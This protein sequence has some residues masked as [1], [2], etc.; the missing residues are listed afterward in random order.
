LLPAIFELHGNI[1]CNFVITWNA[2]VKKYRNFLARRAGRRAKGG[3][4]EE[5]EPES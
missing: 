3:E 4:P 2:T 1:V 5:G